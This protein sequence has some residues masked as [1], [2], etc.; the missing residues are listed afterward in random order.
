MPEYEYVCRACHASFS[1][2]MSVGEH[3]ARGPTCPSCN[4]SDQAEQQLAPV[5]VRTEKKS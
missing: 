5:S 3:D 2:Q 4:R 1:V